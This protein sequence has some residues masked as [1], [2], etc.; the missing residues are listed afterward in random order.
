MRQF[1]IVT[2]DGTK[3]NTCGDKLEIG[4]QSGDLYVTRS[5][6]SIAA[7]VI[8]GRWDFAIDMSVEA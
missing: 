2:S 4:P 5:D 1:K 6:G 3:I 7:A 8:S